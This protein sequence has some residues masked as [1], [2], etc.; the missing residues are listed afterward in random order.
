MKLGIDKVELGI[1]IGFLIAPAVLLLLP[2]DFFD[3]GPA[4]C[5]SRLL[6]NVE[7]PGCG[8]TRAT[9]HLIHAEW[10][11]A[12]EYNPIVV[13]TTPILIWLWGQNVRWL[14]RR[15]RARQTPFLITPVSDATPSHV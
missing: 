10:H 6:L 11:T 13:I 5:P 8:L 15:F 1:R 12:L 7:C 2:A 3:Y 9:Q 14:W 4:L